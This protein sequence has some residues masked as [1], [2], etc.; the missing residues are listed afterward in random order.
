M[1]TDILISFNS[2]K[3]TF[4]KRRRMKDGNVNVRRRMKDGDVNV[5]L[6]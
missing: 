3:K 5:H 4:R 2:G 1:I 6:R